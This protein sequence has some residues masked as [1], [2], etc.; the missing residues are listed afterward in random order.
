MTKQSEK[1]PQMRLS[2]PVPADLVR[3]FGINE[4]TPVTAAVRGKNIILSIDLGGQLT[5]DDLPWGEEKEENLDD[6]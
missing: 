4:K 6:N 5:I 2:Y 3:A 1:M